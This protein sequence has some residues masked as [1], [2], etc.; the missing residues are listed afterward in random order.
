[1]KKLTLLISLSAAALVL[2]ACSKSA[3]LPS[4]VTVVQENDESAKNVNL[5]LGDTLAVEM[6][7]NMT[8]GFMWE[9]LPLPAD[10]A[11]LTLVEGRYTPG[12]SAT[13]DGK[14]IAGA[15]GK[16]TYVMRTVHVGQQKLEFVYRRSFEKDKPP[17]KTFTV[18]V[19]VK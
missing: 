18:N 11:G 5:V 3:R 15:P 19:T 6:P 8:T 4:S 1:M 7:G 9:L 2:G 10:T 12:P 14:A 16:F 17:A 13:A